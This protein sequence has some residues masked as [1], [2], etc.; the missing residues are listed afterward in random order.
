MSLLEAIGVTQAWLGTALLLAVRVSALLI[1]AAPFAAGSIPLLVRAAF[2]LALGACLAGLVP[3]SAASADFGFARIVTG[4]L[5]EAALGATLGLGINIAFAAFSMA[6]RLLD[7]QISFG[8][9]QIYDPVSQTQ[10]P[11]LTSTFNQLAVVFFF[12]SD[13]HHHVMR[14]LA[15]S[16]ERFP[17]GSPWALEQA[18]MPVI[19]QVGSMFALGFAIAAPVVF[20]LF[21]VEVGLGVLARN[22]PQMNM[23]VL[24]IPIKVG[25]GLLALALSFVALSTVMG[26]VNASIFKTWEAVF[27]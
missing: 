7:L 25:V 19:H 17:A 2:G 5:H 13:A 14:G 26:R 8:I 12:L 21:L 22:L 15:L 18:V 9:G 11:V 27:V 20:C 24:A 10:L 23:F 1:V 6:G 16:V 3:P 4:A